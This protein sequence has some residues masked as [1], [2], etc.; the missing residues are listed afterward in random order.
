MKST[1]TTKNILRKQPQ[2][3]PPLQLDIALMKLMDFLMSRSDPD[4]GVKKK[5]AGPWKDAHNYQ[6]GMKW[7][8]A[9][10]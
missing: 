7:A 2:P 1:V 5:T 3:K 9:K 10:K 4:V 6:E 8:E